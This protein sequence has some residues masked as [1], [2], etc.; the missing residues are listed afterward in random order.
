MTALS[1]ITINDRVVDVND[2]TRKGTVSDVSFCFGD[3][4]RV[5]WDDVK[6]MTAPDWQPLSSVRGTGEKGGMW[7]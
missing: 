5:H 7:R 2:E 6:P 1:S 3:E 4:V